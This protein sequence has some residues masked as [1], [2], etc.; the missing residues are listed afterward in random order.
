MNVDHTGLTFTPNAGKTG[1]RKAM[2]TSE[3][4]ESGDT[5]VSAAN[6]KR[7]STGV[8]AV[9]A[10]GTTLDSFCGGGVVS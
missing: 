5:S 6:D 4:V 9:A 2:K 1:S 10:D 3:M 7:Q 8:F